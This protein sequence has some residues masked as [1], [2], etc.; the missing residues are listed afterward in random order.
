M[1]HYA[2]AVLSYVSTAGLLSPAVTEVE[3]QTQRICWQLLPADKQLAFPV[4]P[5]CYQECFE[6]VLKLPAGYIPAL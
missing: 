2:P 5:P 3:P 1:S 6:I 4:A